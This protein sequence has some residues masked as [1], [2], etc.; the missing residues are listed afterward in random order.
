MKHVVLGVALLLSG[1]AIAGQPAFLDEFDEDTFD[2][3]WQWYVPSAGPTGTLTGSEF[4]LYMPAGSYDAWVGVDRAPRLR[5][6]EFETA[7]DFLIETRVTLVEPVSGF[8]AIHMGLIVEYQDLAGGPIDGWFYGFYTT[9]AT[10]NLVFCERVGD[11]SPQSPANVYTASGAAEVFLKIERIKDDVTFFYREDVA[12]AWAVLHKASCPGQIVNYVGMVGKS[13]GSSLPG[14]AVYDYFKLGDPES[15]APELVDAAP[16]TAIPDMPFCLQTVLLKGFPLPTW[17]ISSSPAPANA[18]S[19]SATGLI[20]WLPAAADLGTTFTFTVTAT[21]MVAPDSTTLQVT[22][23]NEFSDDFDG[24]DLAAGLMLTT[25]NPG[26]TLNFTDGWAV[27]AHDGIGTDGVT[28]FD[29]WVGFDYMPRIEAHL[30]TC[31]DFFIETMLTAPATVPDPPTDFHVGIYVGFDDSGFDGF[32]FGPYR[33]FGD[34]KL[35]RAG[36]G[37]HVVALGAPS[38]L[39]LRLERR[40]DTYLFLYKTD[41]GDAWLEYTQLTFPGEL[42]RHIGLCSKNWGASPA[43]SASFDY[44]QAGVPR[45]EPPVLEDLCP[46]AVNRATVGDLFAKRLRYMAGTPKATIVTVA[47]IGAFDTATG[48][49]SVTPA[50]AGTQTVTVTAEMEGA[51]PVAVTFD[52]DVIERGAM[53]ESFEVDTIDDLPLKTPPRELFNP[54]A[55]DPPPF[56]IVGDA[57]AKNLELAVKSTTD[58]GVV[59]DSWAGFD[60]APQMRVQAAELPDDLGGDFTIETKLT[61]TEYNTLGLG[62]EPFQYGLAVG[63]G[64]SELIFWGPYMS[65]NVLLEYSGLN[66][67]HDAVSAAETVTLRIRRE[68]DLYYFFLKPEGG[69]WQFATTL[70][71]PFL[72]PPSFA[73]LFVKTWG[74]AGATARAEFEYFDIIREGGVEPDLISV[75]I[76][77]TNN[78]AKIDIAD[79]ISLLGYLF[80]GGTK[81]PPGCAK[82]ADANDDDKLDI[83]DAIKILGYLFASGAMNAPDGSIVS[84]REGT[85]AACTPYAAGAPNFPDTV[86]T[87]PACEMQCQ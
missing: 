16:A 37:Y 9:T 53:F 68:C 41:F 33:N 23:L 17:T 27:L 77:D 35:E 22:V 20:E 34:L 32:F 2:A 50:A 51:A 64:I 87:L 67:I 60:N 59:Y 49:Y 31:G 63:F 84:S 81:P 82:A 1:I 57:G 19:V 73:G 76:G 86:N 4:E 42:V 18:P 78:D 36:L 79:A 26:P 40:G 30:P 10:P 39:S 65:T 66:A 55:T 54:L 6:N 75:R 83:A 52:L 13:W 46:D 70:A 15:I 47:P 56:G 48:I 45:V 8:Q 3:R 29:T 21:N 69:D 7:E 62:N 58:G 24:P 11:R 44:L 61:L 85:P 38:E 43:V 72:S 74:A 71:S 12:D 80:G 28:N 5:T 25:P 14:R